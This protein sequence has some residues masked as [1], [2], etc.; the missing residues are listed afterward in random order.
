MPCRDAARKPFRRRFCATILRSSLAC[1]LMSVYLFHGVTSV[2]TTSDTAQQLSPVANWEPSWAASAAHGTTLAINCWIPCQKEEVTVANDQTPRILATLIVLQ[3]PSKGSTAVSFS[4][5]AYDPTVSSLGGL[6]LTSIRQCDDVTTSTLTSSRWTFLGSTIVACMTGL[7]SD[8]DHI[9]RTLQQH[10]DRQILI[11][12]ERTSGMAKLLAIDLIPVISQILREA[13]QWQG[14]GRPLGVQTLLINGGGSSLHKGDPVLMTVD[15]G[16]G[17]RHWASGVTAIGRG[18]HAVRQRLYR[19][20]HGQP[21]PN[22]H[23]ALQ[24]ALRASSEATAPQGMITT[25]TTSSLKPCHYQALLVWSSQDDQLC[26]GEVDRGQ[27]QKI[28]D[29]LQSKEA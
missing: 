16:G 1:C 3:S 15:P 8:V 5:R 4:N 23:R 14:G 6:E 25:S 10:V 13:S 22:A 12:A 2:P 19:H 29:N 20:L 11:Y 9:I 18:A 17:Y 24:V 21:M 28:L 27:I 7:A 26:V